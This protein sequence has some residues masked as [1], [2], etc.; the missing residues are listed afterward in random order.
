MPPTE[1]QSKVAMTKAHPICIIIRF[2]RHNIKE[3]QSY[4]LLFNVKVGQLDPNLATG[5][6]DISSL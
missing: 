4:D 6:S 1:N 5:I 2:L 3:I